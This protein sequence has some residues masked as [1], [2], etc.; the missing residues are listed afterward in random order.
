MTDD[1]VTLLNPL[2]ALVK[3]EKLEN[4]PLDVNVSQ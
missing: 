2:V 1:V 4:A 3:Q